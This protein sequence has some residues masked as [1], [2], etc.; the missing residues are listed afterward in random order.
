[1]DSLDKVTESA[2]DDEKAMTEYLRGA[3]LEVGEQQSEGRRKDAQEQ[4]EETQRLDGRLLLSKLPL[5]LSMADNGK[6][7]RGFRCSCE[8]SPG[9]PRKK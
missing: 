8:M 4:C 9:R 3:W 1:M 6:G 7:R 5:A 2:K